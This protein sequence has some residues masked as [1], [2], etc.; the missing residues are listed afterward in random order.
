MSKY[1]TIALFR[2]G[3]AIHPGRKNEITCSLSA[4]EGGSRKKHTWL[5]KTSDLLPWL[6]FNKQN[7]K[8]S[9]VGEGVKELEFP[10]VGANAGKQDDDYSKIKS[11]ITAS[12]GNSTSRH[13]F[14]RTE[15]GDF[16]QKFIHPCSQQHESQ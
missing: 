3:G 6:L 1:V 8:T 12:S 9:S 11:R 15:N 16:K 4:I 13:T 14:K 7:L 10:T 2:Q 5:W